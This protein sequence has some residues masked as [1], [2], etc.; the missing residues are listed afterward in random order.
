MYLLRAPL[1][2]SREE[3]TGRHRMR[4]LGSAHHPAIQVRH[5]VCNQ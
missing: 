4:L 5:V 3:R 2:L 1:W